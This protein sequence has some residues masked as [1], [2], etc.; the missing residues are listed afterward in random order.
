MLTKDSILRQVC[1]C[2]CADFFNVPTEEYGQY[3]ALP[4]MTPGV[5]YTHKHVCLN[6]F[7]T[8]HKRVILFD[9]E[10]ILIHY[11]YC[12]NVNSDRNIHMYIWAGEITRSDLRSM[13]MPK[14]SVMQI[15]E[16]VVEKKNCVLIWSKV[17]QSLV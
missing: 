8:V 10:I 6:G 17:Q 16:N 13:S 9:S 1:R 3:S 7:E 14:L 11:V 12:N 2:V 5:Q 15:F 4:G